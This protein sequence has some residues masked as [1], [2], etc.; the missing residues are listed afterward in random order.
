MV[1]GAVLLCRQTIIA[2]VLACNEMVVQLCGAYVG[3]IKR[4]MCVVRYNVLIDYF[5][6]L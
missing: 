6:Y 1:T 2:S 5:M 4:Y 3:N